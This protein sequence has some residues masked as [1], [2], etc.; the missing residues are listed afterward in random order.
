MAQ[1]KISSKYLVILNQFKKNI[2][3]FVLGILKRKSFCHEIALEAVSL[4]LHKLI[5]VVTV[6]LEV[7]F[8]IFV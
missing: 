1:I 8:D 5:A 7:G 3:F 4:K 6:T 2:F